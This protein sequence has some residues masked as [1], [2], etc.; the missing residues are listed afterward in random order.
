VRGQINGK[1][2]AVFYSKHVKTVYILVG[3]YFVSKIYK[4]TNKDIDIRPLKRQRYR[5]VI[6]THA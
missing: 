4:Q 6:R 3:K 1:V 5:L 2:S